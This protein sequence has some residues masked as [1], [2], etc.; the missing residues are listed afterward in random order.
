MRAVT[1]D[2]ATSVVVITGASSAQAL[3][4]VAAECGA[5]RGVRGG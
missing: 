5:A 3:Q 2:P 4:A 1:R